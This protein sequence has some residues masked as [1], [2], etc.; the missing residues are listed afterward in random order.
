[1]LHNNKHPGV[2]IRRH[3]AGFQVRWR[4]CND[5]IY[6]Q[7]QVTCT[8]YVDA[9]D[10]AVQLSVRLLVARTS[11]L[12]AHGVVRPPGVLESLVPTWI[13][14][15]TS[16]AKAGSHYPRTLRADLQRCMSTF[17][18][19]T[20]C[21]IDGDAVRSMILHFRQDGRWAIAFKTLG[22]IKG[23]LRWCRDDYE[24]HEHVFDI[25]M[26]VEEACLHLIMS[27]FTEHTHQG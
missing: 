27:Y 26:N 12:T 1:M 18:W 16:M 23:F 17:N 25:H 22:T 11:M 20:T 4:E 15:K 19:K 8:T 5:G 13:A 9:H 24:I 7:K 10:F 6:S 2:A 14:I 3:G 21:D